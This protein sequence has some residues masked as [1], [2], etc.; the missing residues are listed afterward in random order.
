MPTTFS[1]RIS[2]KGN[3]GR[4]SHRYIDLDTFDTGSSGGDFEAAQSALSQVEAAFDAASLAP[5]VKSTLTAIETDN[6]SAG[7]G[8]IFECAVI[9][10]YL[11]AG[12][13]KTGQVSVPAPV[14]SL[15]VG[16]SGPNYNVVNISHPLVTDLALQISQ[17]ARISD[18]EQVDTTVS[19]GVDSG[20]RITKPIPRS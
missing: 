5:I 7:S 10:M 12:G 16:S 15:F 18:G 17:H 3:D 13:E 4:L 20:R 19:N 11:D 8:D 9:N 2:F 6:G 1:A 14:G